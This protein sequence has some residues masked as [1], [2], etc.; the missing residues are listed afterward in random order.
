MF[1]GIKG[2]CEIL[3][4]LIRTAKDDSKGKGTSEFIV[5]VFVVPATY[6]FISSGKFIVETKNESILVLL[7]NTTN[8]YAYVNYNPSQKV[9]IM[10]Q[11]GD[12]FPM[13]SGVGIIAGSTSFISFT[14]YP[15]PFKI[16]KK[17]T[18][19]YYLEND[20]KVSIKV[21]DLTG[22]LLKVILDN[23]NKLKGPH[24]EDFW[25]GTD[26]NGRYVMAGTYLVK[27][28]YCGKSHTRKI[29]FIK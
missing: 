16:G 23:E 11:E 13:S 29:A 27:I 15:N 17:T 5:T 3:N 9:Y 26:E 14:N 10:P 4:E 25:D 22:R 6:A 19:S 12:F 24:N 28:E 7:T 8:V 21:Y 18:L 2:V 1:E 20:C